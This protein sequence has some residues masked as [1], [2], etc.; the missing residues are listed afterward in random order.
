MFSERFIKMIEKKVEGYD[1]KLR[2]LIYSIII[3]CHQYLKYAAPAL[4]TDHK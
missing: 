1:L 4:T 3:C 2:S